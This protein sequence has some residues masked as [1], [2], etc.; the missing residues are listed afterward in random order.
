MPGLILYFF[1]LGVSTAP[2]QR[3]ILFATPVAKGTSSA[4]M[5]MIIMCSIA[6]GIEL[7]NYGYFLY[8]NMMLAAGGIIIALLFSVFIALTLQR[9]N[10]NR[11]T[12]VKHT[13]PKELS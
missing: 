1:S 4:L 12:G 10:K 6:I 3:I 9:A 11:S 5:A 8:G 13:L 2:L 7:G